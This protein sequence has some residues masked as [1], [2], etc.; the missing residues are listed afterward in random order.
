MNAGEVPVSNNLTNYVSNGDTLNC[1]MFTLYSYMHLS[2]CEAIRVVSWVWVSHWS[3]LWCA[4]LGGTCCEEVYWIYA[5]L[6]T[7]A[8][9]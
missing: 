2:C 3:V 8:H 7:A 6:S 9:M 1:R 5:P 4:T